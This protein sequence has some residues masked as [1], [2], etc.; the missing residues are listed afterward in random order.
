MKSDYLQ[1][2]SDFDD[3]KPQMVTL[4]SRRAEAK[5]TILYRITNNLVDVV[6]TPS[7]TTAPSRNIHHYF[8]A[9]ICI[10]AY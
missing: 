4:A 5:L 10:N 1:C 3:Q 8:Q 9:S 6:K 7:L 2:S